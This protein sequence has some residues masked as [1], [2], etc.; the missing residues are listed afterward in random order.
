AMNAGGK[1]AVIWGTTL[2]NLLSWKMVMPDA[3]W[4]EV[5]RLNHNMGKIHLQK[6]VEFEITR[7]DRV[8]GKQLDK[9]EIL[10]IAG[11]SFR[12][13]G[14]GKDVTDKFLS[15]LPGIQKEGCDGLI[16]SSNIV[17]H[18]VPEFT[19]TVCLEF[20]NPDAGKDVSAIVEIKDFIDNTKGVLLAG[21][22][23]LD[24]RYIKAIKYSTKAIRADQPKMLLLADIISDDENLLAKTCSGIVELANER[25][26]EGFI[27]VSDQARQRF[28]SDR[29]RTAAISAH[30]NAFKI[31][32]DVVI[33]LKNL[34]LYSRGIETINIRHSIRNKIESCQAIKQFL[35]D[36]QVELEKRSDT[37]ELF[38]SK[39]DFA[40]TRLSAQIQQWEQWTTY[41]DSL[42][43][44]F[45]DQ[46]DFKF[47][48]DDKIIDC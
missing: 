40:L 20:F 28:W 39:I 45:S 42:A 17:L 41:S 3:N 33:P 31:N 1:K 43:K 18:E 29:A 9:P 6:D 48:N 22:E 21:L 11:A 23:H 5:K 47:A 10:K 4:L 36:K 37:D 15:G 27:A 25:E 12:K 38:V 30:T 35:Q 7:F 16:T 2:D 44:E 13:A 19:R 26:A 46:L 14:L 32:E 34:S 24:A 8:T